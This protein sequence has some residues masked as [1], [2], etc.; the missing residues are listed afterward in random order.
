MGTRTTLALIWGL[1]LDTK[2]DSPP[3]G[4]EDKQGD[5]K[6]LTPFGL[7]PLDV[8]GSGALPLACRGP[9]VPSLRGL[10]SPVCPELAPSSQCPLLPPDE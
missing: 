7:S 1:Q 8:S 3:C 9:R 6:P 4:W 10:S 2:G 5:G